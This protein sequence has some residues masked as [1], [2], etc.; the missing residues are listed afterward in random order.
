MLNR[1]GTI[2][3]L[4]RF[5]SFKKLPEIF[6][7]FAILQIVISLFLNIQGVFINTFLLKATGE[8]NVA[9]KFNM[10]VFFAQA[11]FMV[12][13]VFYVRKRTVIG[14][15][16]LGLVMFAI[17]YMCIIVFGET[18][19]DSYVLLALIFAAAIGFIALPYGVLLS[20]FTSDE[21][22]DI[23]IGYLSMWM[24]VSAL[25]MPA[26]SGLL[27][28]LFRGF[29]GY[30]VL[31]AVAFGITLVSFALTTRIAPN[32]PLERKSNFKAVLGYI[33]SH[34]VDRLMFLASTLSSVREGVFRFILSVILYQFLKNEAIIGLNA[35]ICGIAAV[36]SSWAY[37]KLVNPD[38][39]FKCMTISVSLM[40]AG[41]VLMLFYDG[42]IAIVLFGILSS[43]T[44]IFIVSPQDNYTYLLLQIV[45]RTFDKR[46]EYQTVKEFFLAIGRNTG[47]L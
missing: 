3:R 21:Y 1:K 20:E 17:I 26:L 29:T 42:A 25:V 6:I 32:K 45:P 24:G 4:F 2:S 10:I 31:F 33:I 38:N 36:A 27:I 14:S 18:M 5:F 37:G 23:A 43:L 9:L 7:N 46:P 41:S 44:N 40:M 19:A 34:R 39:R 35:L 12:L 28:S 30:R 16:R 8:L 22:R 47:I 13:S 15:T 11:C